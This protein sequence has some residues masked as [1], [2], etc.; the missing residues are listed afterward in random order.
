MKE[1]ELCADLHIHTVAS[2]HAYSSVSEICAAAAQKGLQLVAITDHGPAMP[3][4]THRYYF[5]NLRALPRYIDGVRVLSGVEANIINYD[6]ELDL[7][8][9]YLRQLDLVWAGLHQP[10]IRPG[11][12]DENTRALVKALENPLV[13][14]IVH[15]GNPEFIIDAEKMV[16]KAEEQQKLIEINNNSF[17]VRSGSRENCLRIA[18]LVKERGGLVA[19]NSDAHFSEDVGNLNRARELLKDAGVPPEQIINADVCRVIDYVERRH[20]LKDQ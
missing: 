13:D 12:R 17:A 3:G 8:P 2:G 7:P 15:P 16:L 5:G 9:S 14:G 18:T 10:C 1:I 4:G 20:R 11:N 6:G 19:A